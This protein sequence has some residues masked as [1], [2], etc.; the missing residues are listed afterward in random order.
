MSEPFKRIQRVP[1]MH[2]WHV[3]TETAP[4]LADDVPAAQSASAGD[5]TMQ[6]LPAQSL[7]IR[8]EL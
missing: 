7:T 6:Y 5:P 4:A 3:A 2:D 8:I 1:A